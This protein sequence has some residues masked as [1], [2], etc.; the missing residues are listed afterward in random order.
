MA[1]KV[2]NT[3]TDFRY[4]CFFTIL[5]DP[6]ICHGCD[7]CGVAAPATDVKQE[8][9]EESETLF[10]AIDGWS[11]LVR[12]KSIAID[13]AGV[14][15]FVVLDSNGKDI[16]MPREHLRSPSNPDI[17]RIPSSAQEYD[18]AT[19]CLT[20]EEVKPIGSPLH[21][22][23]LQQEIL[24][25]HNKLLYLPFTT[26]MRLCRLGVLPKRFLMHVW[27]GASQTVAAQD[28]GVQC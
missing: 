2:I 10:C 26:M 18:S 8:L 27:A 25:L 28:L 4:S 5:P 24:S 13:D 23:S 11:G 16:T 3:A 1:S 15:R 17:G 6:D 22:S 9:F 20:D 14:L 21:L 12:I 19:R 7:G